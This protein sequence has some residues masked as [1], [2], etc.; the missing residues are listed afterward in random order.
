MPAKSKRINLS[1][2]PNRIRKLRDV[3]RQNRLHSTDG[4]LKDT[5]IC[6]KLVNFFM[7]L[8][9][10]ADVQQYLEKNRETLFELIEKSVKDRVEKD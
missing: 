3:G 9:S 7:E 5:V 4:S 2:S 1:I 6:A 10:D 8:S